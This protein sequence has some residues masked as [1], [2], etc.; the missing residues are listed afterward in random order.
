MGALG[1]DSGEG[2]VD[3]QERCAALGVIELDIG[4]PVSGD[5]QEAA[6]RLLCQIAASIPVSPGRTVRGARNRFS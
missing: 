3:P 4:K 1:S 5:A 6:L 2:Q